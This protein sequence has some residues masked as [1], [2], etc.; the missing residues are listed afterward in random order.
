MAVLAV[1]IITRTGLKPV[2][3]AASTAGDEFVN[4]GSEFIHVKNGG[5]TSRIVSIVTP[6]LVDGLAVVD[7]EVTVPAGEEKMI[8]PFQSAVYS[9][10][11]S[12]S[13]TYDSIT[14]LTLAL[15][16]LRA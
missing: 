7:R 13:L 5:G 10:A 8:G 11:G 3:S 2:Y 9:N 6:L 12:V 4:S 1:Q 15:L 16:K 14:S